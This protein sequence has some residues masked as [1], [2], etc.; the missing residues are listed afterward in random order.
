M[1]PKRSVNLSLGPRPELALAALI[2]L[3]LSTADIARELGLEA[4]E[5]TRLCRRH[6]IACRDEVSL[7]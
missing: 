6:G 1:R 7:A 2:D 5:V 4:A 3:E